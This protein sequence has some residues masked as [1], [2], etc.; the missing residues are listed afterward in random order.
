MINPQGFPVLDT[1]LDLN[2]LILNSPMLIDMH[3]N[4][5]ESEVDP[6]D[7]LFLQ[8]NEKEVAAVQLGLVTA[9]IMMPCL[10]V[11]MADLLDK[12]ASAIEVQKFETE[13]DHG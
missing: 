5:H 13:E 2:A 10:E 8:L 9:A 1:G 6:E 4:V 11:D 7:N 12:V 3:L